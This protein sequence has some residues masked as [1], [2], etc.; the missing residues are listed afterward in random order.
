MEPVGNQPQSRAA[1]DMQRVGNA[2]RAARD[3]Q[4]VRAV[5]VVDSLVDRGEAD[6]LIAPLRAQ[7]RRLRPPRRLTFAR[8]LLYPLNPAIMPPGVWLQERSTLPRDRMVRL[9]KAVRRDMEQSATAVEAALAGHTTENP[10]LISKV[11][12]GLW[13]EAASLLEH[14]L[15][16]DRK[17]WGGTGDPRFRP[18]AQATALLLSQAS[19]LDAMVAE[20]AN[21]MLPPRTEAIRDVVSRVLVS[22]ETVLPIFMA[23]MLARLPQAMAD[24]DDLLPGR[25]GVTIRKA[26]DDAAAMLLCRLSD[27]MDIESRIAIGAFADAARIARTMLDF[28]HQLSLR[29]Q[30]RD[31]RDSVGDM[32]RRV[33]SAI[34]VRFR[35]GLEQDLLAQLRESDEPLDPAG[36][37]ALQGVARGLRALEGA[38]RSAGSGPIYDQLLQEA[39]EAIA[40]PR[41]R[42]RLTPADQ[43]RFVETLAGSQAAVAMV[44]RP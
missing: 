21:G 34:R 9:A 37:T 44:T 16:A 31:L 7:L 39:A 11:G 15:G 41:M 8:V 35:H 38:A 24:L 6:A 40:A 19:T 17:A 23:I 29:Q 4:I 1:Q 43:M 25:A 33:D 42:G 22:D 32:R 3:D 30:E 18:L 2:L 20:T 26:R 13:P 12:R 36:V 27:D 14:H 5:Q 10:A 28:L